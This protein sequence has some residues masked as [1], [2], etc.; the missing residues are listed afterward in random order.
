MSV[1]DFVKQWSNRGY[2]KG[3]AQPFW[4][5]LLRDVFNI[6][7]PENF[8][9][10]EVQ[11]PH[12]FIDGLIDSTKTLIEQKS[13]TVSLD[14]EEIF[15][16]AK[17][18]NDALEWS[19]KARWI[20]T[21]NFREFR[22]FDMD[23]KYPEREPLKISL[24]ELPKR[25][26][27]LNFLVKLQNKISVEIELSLQAGEIVGKIYDALHAQ[28]INP[29]SAESLASLNKLCVRIVF[30]L[31]AESSGIFG[32]HKIFREY[33]EGA[34]NIRRDLLDLFDVL[35]TPLELRDP[36]LDD[37]LKKFPFVNGGLFGG[38]IEIPNFTPQIRKLLLEE[39]SSN[40]NWAG[41][42][43]TIFGAVFE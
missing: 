40:F 3:E 22:V 36:Y 11:I 2:E 32:K 30:C 23:K 15:R 9:S 26:S 4:L 28:Y 17:R 10:F 37:T 16:Q 18:Y 31:Y 33:L 27:A 34:R 41:I 38:S 42:S 5:S 1:K 8:I 43:P 12:G 24:F 20:V 29:D 35:N 39:A 25:F 13:S 6:A 14:D 7:E 19:R 21:C